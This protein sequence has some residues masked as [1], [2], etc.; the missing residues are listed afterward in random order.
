MIFLVFVDGWKK[1][2]LHWSLLTV[3]VCFRKKI[4]SYLFIPIF[5][6]SVVFYNLI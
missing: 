2:T 4:A 1:N 3:G 5:I 6:Y